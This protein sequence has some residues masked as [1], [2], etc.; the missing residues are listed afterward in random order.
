MSES[1]YCTLVC[2][3]AAGGR[4]PTTVVELDSKS[5]MV[6]TPDRRSGKKEEFR[7]ERRFQRGLK[8]HIDQAGKFFSI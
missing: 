5:A 6:S 8:D 2:F 7:I 1:L 4:T 3:S